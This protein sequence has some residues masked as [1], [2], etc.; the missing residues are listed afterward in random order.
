MVVVARRQGKALGKITTRSAL[1]PGFHH[2]ET[3]NLGKGIQSTSLYRRFY[4]N[5][6]MLCGVLI[7]EPDG[8][9]LYEGDDVCM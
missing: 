9:R 1:L 5:E 4:E 3:D 2:S 8:E 6:A 7:R